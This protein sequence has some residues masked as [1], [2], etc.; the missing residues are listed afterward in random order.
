MESE[1]NDLA[2]EMGNI[3]FRRKKLI[4]WDKNTIDIEADDYVNDVYHKRR[5]TPKKVPE[6]KDNKP[7]TIFNGFHDSAPDAEDD[8][9][10]KSISNKVLT[11][12]SI[13][14]NI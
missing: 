4:Q 9:G 12:I 14:G 6:K 13:D 1:C 5:K 10:F 8:D 2:E 3:S 11:K 7:K